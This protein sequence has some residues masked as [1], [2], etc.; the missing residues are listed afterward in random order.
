MAESK[1]KAKASQR[2]SGASKTTDRSARTRRKPG[3]SAAERID[4]LREMLESKRQELLAKAAER[5]RV[6]EI[7]AHGDL[8]DQSTDLSER[9]LRMGMAEH[10]REMLA[11]IDEA[12]GKI[13]S[14]GYG[15]C[16]SCGIEIPLERLMAIPTAA[17]CVPCQERFENETMTAAAEEEPPT[18]TQQRNDDLE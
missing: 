6:F 17:F 5:S 3:G 13:R 12:L 1:K 15:I 8:V 11:A 14:G 18:Y 10:D 4:Q 9:E 7:N 16:G 2:S